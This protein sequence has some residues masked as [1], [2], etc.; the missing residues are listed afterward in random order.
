[1]ALILQFFD[2]GHVSSSFFFFLLD[3]ERGVNKLKI[4]DSRHCVDYIKE[5]S[6]S[7]SDAGAVLPFIS[8]ETETEK[9]SN[10]VT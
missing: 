10:M 9:P 1:M 5:S 3:L 8:Q 4:T 7:F 2:E 6:E